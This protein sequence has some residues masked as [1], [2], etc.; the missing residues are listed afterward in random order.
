M[1]SNNVINCPFC[2]ADIQVG[3]LSNSIQCP[4]CGKMFNRSEGKKTRDIQMQRQF[5]VDETINEKIKN[6]STV[7][8]AEKP[9]YC[10]ECG[11][12]LA[13]D[14]RYC[15]WCGTKVLAHGH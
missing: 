10:T 13:Y 11:R 1:Y 5:I 3:D 2:E 8:P 15:D 12:K 14:A 9:K 4:F 6:Q 7:L